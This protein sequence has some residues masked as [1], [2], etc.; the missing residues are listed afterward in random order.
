MID[1]IKK[2][3]PENPKGLK[4]SKFFHG[5]PAY[6]TKILFFVSFGN[7][8]VGLIKMVRNPEEND[9]IDREIEGIKYFTSLKLKTPQIINLGEIKGLKYIFQ[10]ILPGRSVNKNEAVKIFS[11]VANYH[12]FVNKAGQIK[13]KEIIEPIKNLKIQKD[14]EILDTLE[15]LSLRE[16]N[17]IYLAPQHGD[18]TYRNL[19]INGDDISFIDFENFGLRPVW[20][21]DVIHYLS[22]MVDA[23][24]EKR[25]VADTA[26]YFV[27]ASRKY[28]NKHDLKISDEESADLFLLDLLFEILKKNFFSG[29]K[30]IIP[31]I[32]N[33]WQ[34]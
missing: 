31:A 1:E 10:E 6:A 15:Q 19:I 24:N 3:F 20:G 21:L 9:L 11:K 27:E 26:L 18:L 22:R 25:N 16:N 13:I 28:R 29:R 23:N 4:I 5:G 8:P 32:K 2:I 12:N 17:K 33:I 7:Q 14:R 30:E 34:K